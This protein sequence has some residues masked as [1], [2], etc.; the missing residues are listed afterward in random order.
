MNELRWQQPG[1]GREEQLTVVA[2]TAAAAAAVALV[3]SLVALC[4]TTARP[5]AGLARRKTPPGHR[6]LRLAG[7]KE[8]RHRCK[9]IRPGIKLT[10]TNTYT[11]TN[12][13]TVPMSVPYINTYTSTY[14]HLYNCIYTMACQLGDPQEGTHCMPGCTAWR[15]R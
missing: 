1:T 12:G 4:R 15:Y 8:Y 2:A 14:Q 10:Y 13:Y 5:T 9:T 7:D 3:T 11:N 6:G